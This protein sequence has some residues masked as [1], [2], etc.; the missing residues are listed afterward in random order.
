MVFPMS[1]QPEHTPSSLPST[2][3]H[4][5][6]QDIDEK[7]Q[8]T[9]ASPPSPLPSPP[10]FVSAE[11]SQRSHLSSPSVNNSPA[12]EYG[13]LERIPTAQDNAPCAEV[14]Q[15]PTVSHLGPVY[16]V[17]TPNQKRFI[18]F[19]ASWAGFFSPV[20]GQIYF[21]ALNSLSRDLHVS[22]GMINLTLTSYMVVASRLDLWILTDWPPVT[23]FPG[24]GPG[25]YWR[26]GRCHRSAPGICW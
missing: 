3:A 18:V 8:K 25:L 14:T 2:T 12:S 1:E 23:D 15:T 10:P 26:F 7:P 16:S 19:M 22:N 24:P 11:T 21:P 17:F 6:D 20:S 9:A 5:S 4:G 13:S